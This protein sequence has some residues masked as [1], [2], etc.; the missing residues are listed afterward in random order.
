MSIERDDFDALTEDD[1]QELVTAQ[2]P[3]G[4]RLDYKATTYGSGDADKR[5]FAKDISSF[6]NSHGG[7]LLIGIEE[8]RGVATRVSGIGNVNTDAELQRLDQIARS[9]LEPRIAGLRM[10]AVRLAAG[11]AV[12]ALRIQRSWNPPHRVIMHGSNRFF[13]RNSSGV[14]EPNVEELRTMFTLSTSA[15]ERARQ[16][17]SHRIAALQASAGPRPLVG[18]GRLVLHIVPVAEV[19]LD[20]RRVH[21]RRDSFV[22][23]GS[24]SQTSSFNY[25]GFINERGG[26]QNHGYT[27]VYRNGALEATK[28]SILRTHHNRLAIPGIGLEDSFFQRLAS[29]IDGLQD[30]DVPPPLIVMLTLEGVG[31]AH[32]VVSEQLWDDGWPP[33]LPENTI[34]LPEC[35]IEDYGEEVTYH[36]AVKPA[37]DALWNAAGRASAGSF[38]DEGRWVGSRRR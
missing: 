38:D 37:L 14:Y 1:L 13:A 33:T 8:K 36:Q 28:A 7:H 4:L 17:R 26:E 2:V 16:F 32:Y 31:G 30:V 35:V 24:M 12:I 20:M 10:R 11:G 15:L 34:V 5:E 9:G 25:Y 19:S 29:Y 6:A 3:E 21:A 18:E 23:I 22:P 27:Q